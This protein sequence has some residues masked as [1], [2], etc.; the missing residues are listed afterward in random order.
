MSITGSRGEINIKTILSSVLWKGGFSF[1][2]F[3]VGGFIW[4][5]TRWSDLSFVFVYFSLLQSF[6]VSFPISGTQIQGLQLALGC[7]MHGFAHDFFKKVLGLNTW[8]ILK[9][10]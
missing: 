1:A 2:L 6:P 5:E 7:L 8:Y 10:A 4:F 9:P 3:G